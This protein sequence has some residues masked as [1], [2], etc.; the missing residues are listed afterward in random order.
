MPK[1]ISSEFKREC[2]ELVVVHGHKHKDA[3]QAMGVGLSSIQRWVTQYRKEQR[4]ETPKPAALTPEQ[5][6]IQELEKQVKQLQSDNQLLKKA[7]FA[8]EMNNGNK[9]R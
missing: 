5:Q 6:R 9:S 8:M 1:P 4:G 3:A 7:F 2:V